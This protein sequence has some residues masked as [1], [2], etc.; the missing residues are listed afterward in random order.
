M[1]SGLVSGRPKTLREYLDAHGS[2]VF[3]GPVCLF[4]K[5]IRIVHRK[6]GDESEKWSGY[7]WT[8]S[9]IPSFAKLGQVCGD[10]RRAKDFNGRCTEA[11]DLH[12]IIKQVHH[13]EPFLQVDNGGHISDPFVHI[14]SSWSNFNHLIKIRFWK[15][16]VKN[17]YL[18]NRPPY[19]GIDSRVHLFVPE[20]YG[21]AFDSRNL[22][23]WK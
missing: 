2:K 5:S 21:L 8:N 19:R 14:L 1:V 22:L 12:V 13:S 23:Q 10:G 7:F 17:V 20:I 11:D 15:D 9:A 18:H 3:D 6:G 4:Q 16:V